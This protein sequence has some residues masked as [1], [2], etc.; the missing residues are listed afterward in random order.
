M[1]A[2]GPLEDLVRRA[3]RRT[4]RRL[5]I[6]ELAFAATVAM[7]GLIALLVLGTQILEWYWLAVLF[8]GSFAWGLYRT[9][10]RVPSAYHVARHVDRGLGLED[11]LSTAYYFL[12]PPGSLK[13]SPDVRDGQRR[14]AEDLARGADVKKALPLAVPRALRAAGLLGLVAFGLFALRYGLTHSLDLRPP[15]ARASFDVFG[16]KTVESAAL[17]KPSP[18]RPGNEPTPAVGMTVDEGAAKHDSRQSL[19]GEPGEAEASNVPGD[20]MRKAEGPSTRDAGDEQ[21]EASSGEPA[22]NADSSPAADSENGSPSSPARK[23]NAKSGENSD[24]LNKLRDAMA[25]L[26][27]RLKIK[28]PSSGEMQTAEGKGAM[29]S[30]QRQGK[31]Q[32]GPPGAAR[33]EMRA[34]ANAEKE[35]GEESEG[36]ESRENAA[37]KPGRRNADTAASRKERSGIGKEEGD[38]DIREAEQLEAMGKISEIFGK[39]AENL[40]GEVT[41]E[42]TSGDQKL[43]TPY[44]QSGAAHSDT[45]GEIHRDEVPL[46]YQ[47]Y[48]QQYFEQVR[49]LPPPK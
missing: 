16:T 43:K 13:V 41:V 30:R 46:I 21:A 2:R 10:R 49:K 24:L 19:A 36:A 35:S 25:D 11:S 9:L 3:R 40:K 1:S 28:P 48:V 8:G 4:V 6:A 33:E 38:K 22:P 14:Q 18:P 32:K 15:I 5:V 39:R 23:Q 37:G 45:G 29:E 26:L 31:G 20:A 7:A 17:P 44:S 42:V 47:Q 34:D 12:N 27:S